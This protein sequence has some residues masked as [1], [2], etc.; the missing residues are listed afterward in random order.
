MRE[1]QEKKRRQKLIYSKFTLVILLILVLVL[2]RATWN[3]YSKKVDSKE[4]RLTSE[5]ELAYLE[6]QQAKLLSEIEALKT[7]EGQEAE[8]RDTYRLAKEGEGL[9]VVVDERIPE[10]V[11]EKKGVIHDFWQAWKGLFDSF[12]FF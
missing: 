4:K 5:Q 6:N 8:I 2:S 12:F 1:F 11:E 9:I 7:Q 3:V 10:V